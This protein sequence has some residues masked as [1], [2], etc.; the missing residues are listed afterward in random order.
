MPEKFT[1]FGCQVV[2]FNE[3]DFLEAIIRLFQPFVD[4]IVVS[5]GN[6]SWMGN[7]E[8][9]GSVEMV[10]LPLTKEFNNVHLIKGD[11]T[12]EA[13]QRNNAL[14]HLNE[15]NYIFVVDTDELW[16]SEYITKVKEFA[17]S[18]PGYNI[19]RANWNTRFKN[20]NWRVEP[21]EQFKP[22]VLI[23]NKK[24]LQFT[25]NRHIQESVN[26]ISILIP[27]KTALVEHLS[28]VRSEPSKIKEKIKQQQSV[29]DS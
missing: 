17:L 12:T 21:R 22:I 23:N 8:N 24:G 2:A 14:K 11:W 6:K 7:I 25:E 19:F 16:A 9:D 4:E 10:V 26:T 3:T 5:T 15:C 28:F 18:H 1:K 27:E 29:I 20:I 13:Q